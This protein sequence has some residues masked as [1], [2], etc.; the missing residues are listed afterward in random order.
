MVGLYFALLLVNRNA[1]HNAARL[2]NNR[3][4]ANF[5]SGRLQN[6]VGT[7]EHEIVIKK[8]RFVARCSNA[9]DFKDVRLFVET[10]ADP[11]ARHNCWGWVGTHTQRSDDDGEPSG[12][13]G[14]P[15]LSAIESEGVVDAVVLVTRYKAKDAPMLGAGGLLRAYADATRQVL[16]SARRMDV[17][18][19]VIMELKFLNS[20]IGKIQNIIAAHENR[21]PGEGKIRRLHTTNGSECSLS[22]EIETA[23]MNPF[24]NR[25]R[26]ATGGS[27]IAQIAA[28]P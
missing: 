22:I 23:F 9:S 28:V 24:I 12:T 20:D 16:R 15:I 10:Y 6:V 3:Q 25:L 18:E 17:V 21:K 14:R 7:H 4:L 8:S 19:M 1:L 13:A 11:K 27:A 2:K 26:E 5:A